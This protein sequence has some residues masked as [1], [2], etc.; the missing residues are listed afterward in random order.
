MD[1]KLIE[2][3]IEKIEESRKLQEENKKMF[4]VVYGMLKAEQAENIELRKQNRNLSHQVM[5]LK[6]ENALYKS[7]MRELVATILD[8]TNKK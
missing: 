1:V 7:K 3:M 4:E 8:E 5:E 6:E 2:N